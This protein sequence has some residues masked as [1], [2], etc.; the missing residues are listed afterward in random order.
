MYP[1]LSYL[2]HDVFGTPVDNAF[3]IVKTFG[4]MLGITFL[5]CAWVL[6][7]EL[8]RKEEEGL[9]KP[10]TRTTTIGT[11]PKWSEALINGLVGFIFGLKLPYIVLNFSEFKADAAAVI[12]SGK[13]NVGI[14]LLGLLV[15]SGYVIW[16][17]MKNK[18]DKPK[19]IK[20]VIHPYQRTG[21]IIIMGA[22]SGILGSRLFSILENLDS[23][24]QDPMD[25]LFSGSGLTVYGGFILGFI[26]VF[27]QVKRYGIK[28]IHMMDAAAPVM[29]VG[30]TVGRLGCQ[31]S[32]DGDWG[33]VN[34]AAK[35]SWF[36][37][38]DWAWAYDYPR[39]VLNEG[40]RIIN[41]AGEY[42]SRLSPPVYPTP[43]YE[44]VLGAIIIAI[45]WFLRKR[46]KVPTKLFF[47]F[48]I[49]MAIE[50]FFIEYIRVNP[51]YNY[52]GFEWSQAQ[53]ISVGVF[54]LGIVALIV[55][56]RRPTTE[57]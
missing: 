40:V 12:F 48:C 7:L 2:L 49:L 31:L 41:C 10:Q 53:Y 1:D 42:C 6:Y 51:R 16:M 37:F 8:K 43:I 15:F 36:I 46:I 55:L 52:L 33:T 54:L 25:Q 14:G 20:E 38:P 18:L 27:Y 4:L 17:G 19:N 23:F 9:I 30:Y 3:S 35:P 50:R 34:E 28:P 57:N 11:G 47:I 29:M 56:S 44:I 5:V 32:G 21:D 39:N 24:W 26:A 22:I 45:L 13:G